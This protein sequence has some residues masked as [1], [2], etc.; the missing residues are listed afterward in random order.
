MKVI[1]LRKTFTFIII[2]IT[3]FL[4]YSSSMG[5]HKLQNL[6]NHPECDCYFR[7]FYYSCHCQEKIHLELGAEVSMIKIRC[8]DG[9][10]TD[11]YEFF[12][13]LF[14]H[15]SLSTLI[16]IG[17]PPPKREFSSI[18]PQ[19]SFSDMNDF[20]D[21][22]DFLILTCEESQN[23]SLRSNHLQNLRKLSQIM[24]FCHSLS[25]IPEDLFRGTSETIEA[26]VISETSI[27]NLPRN[28]FSHFYSLTDLIL[29]QN[30]LKAVPSLVNL[31]ELQSL[32][33]SGNEVDHLDENLFISKENLREINLSKNNLSQ[34][35]TSLCELENLEILNAE[36]NRF[37]HLDLQC[38]A[39]MRSISVISLGG[40]H[41]LELQG[42]VVLKGMLIY[43]E[44]IE[45]TP[46]Q[47]EISPLF[48]KP[49]EHEMATDVSQHE[50]SLD[51]S[52]ESYLFPL[53]SFDGSNNNLSWLPENIFSDMINLWNLDLSSNKITVL[54]TNLFRSNEMLSDI[55]LSN[56][57]I[58][59]I[60]ES[61]FSKNRELENF[62]ISG[63]SISTLGENFF[64]GL[65][66]LKKI[67]LSHNMIEYLPEKILL[68]LKEAKKLVFLNMEGNYLSYLPILFLPQLKELFLGSNEL[69][70]ISSDAL[71]YLRS[72]ERIDLSFNFIKTT[73]SSP[74]QNFEFT[75][76]LFHTHLKHIEHIDISYNRLT[77]HPNISE[78]YKTL[79][80]LDLSGN[81]FDELSLNCYNGNVSPSLRTLDLSNNSLRNIFRADGNHRLNFCMDKLVHLNLSR[82]GIF[83][84]GCLEYKTF[85]TKRCDSFL[86]RAHNL[87]VLDLSHNDIE[88][89]PEYFSLLPNLQRVDFRYNKIK[90]IYFNNFFYANGMF[91]VSQYSPESNYMKTDDYNELPSS[92]HLEIDLRHNAIIYVD[93]PET[94][95]QRVPQDCHIDKRFARATILLGHNPILCGCQIYRLLRYSLKEIRPV[96]EDERWYGRRL[97]MP[98]TVDIQS[99]SCGNPVSVRGKHVSDPETWL[100]HLLPLL[101]LCNN[102][103]L[104]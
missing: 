88:V 61:F 10:V 46:G 18:F 49:N 77:K 8:D 34:F 19:R 37:Q 99:L 98:V 87:E 35:P 65:L 7:R 53:G 55:N 78:V 15:L 40:N 38:L 14:E 45:E 72:L 36:D 33:I 84:D 93:L 60:S 52:D 94:K 59:N 96:A 66:R 48:S 83:F 102:G 42:T 69:E 62:N 101:V 97:S 29:M 6:F 50:D 54:P 75:G 9:V 57:L 22:L 58:S 79:V 43:N 86:V 2:C 92:H 103:G 16:V 74:S 1:M 100:H 27:I 30:K 23:F 26:L 85:T 41:L 11:P 47:E 81:V 17:C 44:N 63:N 95:M 20:G 73:D 24:I 32:D 64:F 68:P 70:I 104:K 51:S 12:S 89:V 28:I 5:N 31:T 56:N 3:I 82:N 76:N 39:L 80:S 25:N 4:A 67:D 13:K 91:N 71:K 21:S 90:E